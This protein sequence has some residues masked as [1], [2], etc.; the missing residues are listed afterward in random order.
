MASNGL[1]PLIVDRSSTSS[2]SEEVSGELTSADYA[3]ACESHSRSSF[4]MLVNDSNS[5]V[6]IDSDGR[7]P[8]DPEN[9]LAATKKVP[10]TVIDRLHLDL[11]Q[12]PNTLP[13][14]CF[15]SVSYAAEME[16][17]AQKHNADAF[18]D[19]FEEEDRRSRTEMWVESTSA[20]CPSDDEKRSLPKEE[21]DDDTIPQV[22]VFEC[23]EK[24]VSASPPGNTTTS[25]T[26][27][28]DEPSHSVQ[29]QIN[30]ELLPSGHQQTMNR[31]DSL[32]TSEMSETQSVVSSDI[33]KISLL[34]LRFKSNL[35]KAREDAKKEVDLEKFDRF[36]LY[37]YNKGEEAKKERDEHAAEAREVNRRR[38]RT[39]TIERVVL[40]YTTDRRLS[41]TP[42][43]PSLSPSPD[44]YSQRSQLENSARQL[45]IQPKKPPVV[46][47]DSVTSEPIGDIP[48]IIPTTANQLPGATSS[49]SYQTH[50]C[51]H[52]VI[53]ESEEKQPCSD[54]RSEEATDL[55]LEQFSSLIPAEINIDT[56]VESIDEKSEYL[57]FRLAGTSESDTEEGRVEVSSKAVEQQSATT[58][59]NQLMRIPHVPTSDPV[60]SNQRR[61][62]AP[63]SYK[64]EVQTETAATARENREENNQQSPTKDMQ[65]ETIPTTDSPSISPLPPIMVLADA[66][67]TDVALPDFKEALS[68]NEMSSLE[69]LL[70]FETRPSSSHRKSVSFN[71]VIDASMNEMPRKT[72]SPELYSNVKP[73]LKKDSKQRESMRRL[74]DYTVERLYKDLRMLV[75][76]RDRSVHALELTPEDKVEDLSPQSN[77]FQQK[78]REKLLE[79]KLT[80]DKRID[81]V[82]MKLRELAVDG[83]AAEFVFGVRHSSELT[84]NIRRQLSGWNGFAR[85]ES[86]PINTKNSLHD[87]ELASDFSRRLSRVREQLRR[88]DLDP[89]EDDRTMEDMLMVVSRIIGKREKFT[90]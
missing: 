48:P 29:I 78:Y 53:Y 65:G 68:E 46:Q 87:M 67:E 45:F 34:K 50:P 73:I 81:Q 64:S 89:F 4:A 66:P 18:V 26:G 63:S 43:Q 58:S 75:E 90:S 88:N 15:A 22:R 39:P 79:N 86:I 7:P 11:V 82:W 55:S 37:C 12:L 44:L 2:A 38:G 47:Q 16:R 60:I 6:S 71:D 84:L 19:P 20:A 32:A 8:P 80:L 17:F 27:G 83:P 1:Q 3:M 14:G 74:L 59:T 40:Y 9:S 61:S 69:D 13:N 42:S 57:L 72:P 31:L 28:D 76:E 33:D 62:E 21:S 54:R 70:A 35:Q 41:L 24:S 36:W 5:D 30:D 49:L 23:S 10:P 77:I 51:G 52:I 56:E 25:T 85:R